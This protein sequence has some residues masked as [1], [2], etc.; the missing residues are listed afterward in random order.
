MSIP[1]LNVKQVWP[2][3]CPAVPVVIQLQTPQN[4]LW[5]SSTGYIPHST[6][7]RWRSEV[8]W[9]WGCHLA[10]AFSS[11]HLHWPQH[12][13]TPHQCAWSSRPSQSFAG[14]SWSEG[15]ERRWRWRRGRIICNSIAS[16]LRGN[17]TP[18]TSHATN[19]WREVSSLIAMLLMV[20]GC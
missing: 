6:G 10:L 5:S 4:Q 12:R 20:N 3:K 11:L 16:K 2:G 13:C 15:M 8:E 9:P 19:L 1:S 18:V 7:L 14:A 17:H